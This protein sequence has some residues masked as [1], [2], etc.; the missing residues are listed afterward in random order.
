MVIRM[1]GKKLSEK[2]RKFAD[3]Y[4]ET[5]NASEAARLAGYKG[6]NLNNIASENL[7]KLGIKSYINEKLEAIKSK[8]TADITEVLEFFTSVM[9]GEV[10]DAFDLDVDATTRMNAGKELLKRYKH[11]MS[12]E[13]EQIRIEILR[14]E[15]EIKKAELNKIVEG[16]DN[17]EIVIK[18]E[19]V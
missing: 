4:L 11:S 18:F 8:K 10:K 6:K 15:L 3:F 13:E 5:G 7:A 9:R 12:K 2:Q 1:K 16:D 14:L 17:E 19:G